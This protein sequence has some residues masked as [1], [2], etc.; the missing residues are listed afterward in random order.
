MARLPCA[1]WWQGAPCEVSMTEG[2]YRFVFY[3]GDGTGREAALD[4]SEIRKVGTDGRRAFAGMKPS[5]AWGRSAF[6]AAVFGGAAGAAEMVAT[7][8]EEPAFERRWFFVV[9]TVDGGAIELEYD[10][11]RAYNG[12]LFRQGVATFLR[13]FKRNRELYAA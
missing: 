11:S 8:K 6:M 4:K 1:M 9:E 10:R 2:Q 13:D 3:A 12:G 7:T 5:F